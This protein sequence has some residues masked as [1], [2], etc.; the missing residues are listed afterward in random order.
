MHPELV[1]TIAFVPSFIIPHNIKSI[2]MVIPKLFRDYV[3]TY[4][5]YFLDD[6]EYLVHL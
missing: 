4:A 5:P 3:A 2:Q 6:D 1:M